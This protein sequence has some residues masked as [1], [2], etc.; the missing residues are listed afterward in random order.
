LKLGLNHI[1]EPY[2]SIVE[3]VFKNLLNV[4]KDDLISFV[5]YGSVARGQAKPES[6]IDMLIVVKNLPK[7][8]LERT[9]LFI[10]LIERKVEPLLQELMDRGYYIN[11]SPILKEPE[12]ASKITPLYLDMVEDAVIIYDKNN[13]ITNVLLR[14]KKRLSELGAERV[15]MGRKWFWI[16]KKDY[17]FGEVIEIE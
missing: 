5:I 13:F 6:D 10:D 17:R 4:F 8:R 14:L 1:P 7:N 3:L 2:K 9:A 12:E 15:W 11:L 16:L